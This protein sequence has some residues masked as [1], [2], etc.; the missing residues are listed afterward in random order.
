MPKE[1]MLENMLVTL[2]EQIID[3]L[4][5]ED[6]SH[7]VTFTLFKE[8]ENNRLT[9]FIRY[10]EF[11]GKLGVLPSAELAD[12]K[13]SE[14]EQGIKHTELPPMD[15]TLILQIN[16]NQYGEVENKKPSE[17]FYHS[18]RT[19]YAMNDKVD[20]FLAVLADKFVQDITHTGA[21]NLE[22]N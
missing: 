19:P 9:S 15:V 8:P 5:K 10:K 1:T 3:K 13:A 4:N 20:T 12:Y 22:N 11:V 6:T 14:K 21:Y 16:R 2:S 7:K 17:M 18:Y